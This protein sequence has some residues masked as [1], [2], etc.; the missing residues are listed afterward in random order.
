MKEYDKAIADYDKAIE[1]DPKYAWAYR[2][3]AWIL[4]TCPNG[5]HRDGRQA[6]ASATRAC[7]LTDWKGAEDLDALAAAYAETGDF[8]AAVKW[9]EKALELLAKDDVQARK[10]YSARLALYQA[11]KAYHEQQ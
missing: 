1:L 11:R 8:E 4:A 6:V 7:E 9:Q 2:N 5:K 3:L 10:G